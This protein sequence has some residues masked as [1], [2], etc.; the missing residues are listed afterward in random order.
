MQ[1][2][3]SYFNLAGSFFLQGKPSFIAH[4][5]RDLKTSIPWQHGIISGTT[6]EPIRPV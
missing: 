6:L 2:H 5:L 3:Y 1:L 4:G